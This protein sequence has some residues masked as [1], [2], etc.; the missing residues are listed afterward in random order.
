M[1]NE[2]EAASPED[3]LRGRDAVM[4]GLIASARTLFAQKGP[5]NVS[6]RD[7]A[8]HAG[9]NHGLVHRHFGSKEG[10][11]KA[12]MDGFAEK[13]RAAV[14]DDQSTEEIARRMH[15]VLL[16][17]SDLLR[18]LG[19]LLLAGEDPRSFIAPRGGVGLLVA[20]AREDA[21]SN[22]VSADGI[23]PDHAVLAGA[24]LA[25]GWILFAPFFHE[26]AGIKRAAEVKTVQQSVNS[27]ALALLSGSR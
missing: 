13:F 3:L 2:L 4:D 1:P 11:L 22:P 5:S 26:V 15:A 21:K 27:I 17:E 7:V 12:V 25:F 18:I 9:V 14:E 10:L 6:V 19:H 16:H 20:K 23:P 24:A 8:A